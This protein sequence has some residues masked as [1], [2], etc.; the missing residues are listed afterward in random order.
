MN[1]SLTNA[2]YD[3]ELKIN[4]AFKKSQLKEA[5]ERGEFTFY[6]DKDNVRVLKDINTFTGITVNKNSDF[7]SNQVIRV[8]DS[9]ANDTA[10]IFND[11]YLGKVQNSALGRD[12]FKSELISYHN[13]LQAIEAIENF[14]SE[15][16]TVQKGTEKGD[17]IVN[18]YIEPVGAM[19]KLYM[20][21]IVE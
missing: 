5:I 6:G 14:S 1:E 8:L 11:Y 17:V 13:Q 3:G 10:R 21:C 18:E 7:T 12:I 9:V 15:D 4:T 19:E 16:I 2:K 20:T